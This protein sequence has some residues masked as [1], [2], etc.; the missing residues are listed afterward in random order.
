LPESSERPFVIKRLNATWLPRGHPFTK[1]I[2]LHYHEVNK[3]ILIKNV[4]A[5]LE[6]KYFIKNLLAEV[7]KVIRKKC[8]WYKRFKAQ[9]ENPLMGDLPDECLGVYELPFTFAMLDIAGP[10]QVR[11]TRFTTVKR[12]ILIYTCLTTRAVNLELI[13]DLTADATMLAIN[14]TIYRVGAPV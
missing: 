8:I 1:M 5:C 9:P 13:R 11:L 3:H 2:I 7:K 10:I 4:V 6:N 12:Y 14:N